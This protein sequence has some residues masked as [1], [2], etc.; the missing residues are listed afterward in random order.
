MCIMW[1][2]IVRENQSDLWTGCCQRLVNYFLLCQSHTPALQQRLCLHNR[3]PPSLKKKEIIYHTFLSATHTFLFCIL[4]ILLAELLS[5]HIVTNYI[6]SHGDKFVFV[7]FCLT[8]VPRASFICDTGVGTSTQNHS[9]P[10]LQREPSSGGA[11]QRAQHCPEDPELTT[12]FS[13]DS[14]V[15]VIMLLCNINLLAQV[16]Q[17]PIAFQ[18]KCILQEKLST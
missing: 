13:T 10:V 17:L 7:L 2:C 1:E 6:Y 14:A 15:K 8:L 3:P 16:V 12:D 4:Q 11:F 18:V 5:L 9:P